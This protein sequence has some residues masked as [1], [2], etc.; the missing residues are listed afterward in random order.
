MILL[1]HP[2]QENFVRVMRN[3]DLL[4]RNSARIETSIYCPK[5]YVYFMEAGLLND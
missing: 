1:C 3:N 5:N 2:T 4:L